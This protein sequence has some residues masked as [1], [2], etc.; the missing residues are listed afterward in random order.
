MNSTRNIFAEFRISFIKM[1]FKRFYV[2]KCKFLEKL[3]LIKP[4]KC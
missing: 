1:S 3:F 2:K 4:K